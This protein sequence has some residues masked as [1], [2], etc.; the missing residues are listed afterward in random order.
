MEKSV[1]TIRSYFIYLLIFILVLGVSAPESYAATTKDSTDPS[2]EIKSKLEPP[3]D[4]DLLH[5]LPVPDFQL[6]QLHKQKSLSTQRSGSSVQAENF[7]E[8]SESSEPITVIVELATDPL[9]VFEANSPFS[10]KSKSSVN[11][12]TNTLRQ[13]H[14]AFKSAAIL[15]AGATFNREYSNIFNGYSITL[16]ADEVDQLLLIAGVKAVYPNI[17]YKALELDQSSEGYT[18]YMDVSAP[19]IGA[20]TLWASGYTGA[21]IKVGVID[22][23]VDY[24]HP[25]LKDAYKGGYDFVDNDDDPME[26]LPDPTKPIKNG[27]PY[28]TLHGTHVSG[29]IVGQGDPEHPYAGKGWVRGVAPAADLYVYRVLGPY[30]SGTSENVIAA[31]ERA[32]IDDLDVVNLSLGSDLNNEY[33][34]DSIAADNATLAGVTVVLANG[35][36]GPNDQT[37]GSPAASELSISVGASVPPVSTPIFISSAIGNIYAQISTFS[38]DLGEPNQELDLVY[39]NYGQESDYSNLDV[40]GKTVIVS[41]GALSFGEKSMNATAAGA[42]ALIIHNNTPGEFGATLGEPG[43]Y[44]PTYT[45]SQE[46]GLA[47]KDQI[48]QGQPTITFSKI[49]EQDLLA[50]FSSRGPALPNYSIKPDFSA[51]GVGIRSSIPAF[52]GDYSN[53][54]EDLNGTSMAAP[55][56]AGAVAL[57]LEQTAQANLDL[58]PYQIKSILSNNA[59]PLSDR[60]GIAY[61][62]NQQGAGRI[63]L[64]KST[65]ADAIVKVKEPL[66]TQL[67]NQNITDYYTSSLSYGQQQANSEVSKQITIDNIRDTNQI[68]HA[69]VDWYSNEGLTI[70]P[71]QDTVYVNQG[72]LETVFSVELTI[73]DGTPDGMYDG[74]IVLTEETTLHE[75]RVPFS[76]FVGQSFDLSPITA[77]DFSSVVFSPNGDGVSDTTDVSFAVNDDLEYF[78]FLI[79]DGLTGDAIGYT[80][81]SIAIQPIHEKNYYKYTWDGT[82]TTE[83]SE[84]TLPE[85]VYA[86]VPVIVDTNE[87]LEGSAEFFFVDLNAPEI[88]LDSDNVILLPDQPG[89]GSISGDILD[90]LQ[91]NYLYDGTNLDELVGISAL[92]QSDQGL[93]QIDGTIDATG[94]FNLNLPIVKGENTYSIFAYDSVGNGTQ[95]PAKVIHYTQVNLFSAKSQVAAGEAF[96]VVANY[97]VTEDVYSASFSLTYDSKLQLNSIQ[98]SVLDAVYTHLDQV[99]IDLGNGLKQVNYTGTLPEGQGTFAAFNFTATQAGS[100]PF[101]ISNVELLNEEGKDIPVFGLSPVTVKV[102]APVPGTGPDPDPVVTNPNSGSSSSGSYSGNTTSTPQDNSKKFKAGSL[103]EFTINDI[104][105]ATLTV[106][107]SLLTKQIAS[108]TLKAITLDLS[109]IPVDTYDPF[110]ISISS[111][112]VEQLQQSKKDLILVGSNFEIRIPSQSIS[113]FVSK[114]GFRISMTLSKK[115]VGTIQA[116]DGATGKF[117]AP[118]LMIHGQLKE[119]SAPIQVQL[120]LAASSFTDIQKVGIY[121]L[122]GASQ[123]SYFGIPR[124]NSQKNTIQFSISAPGSFTAIETLKSFVD[125][126]KHWAKHEIEVLAAHFLVKGKPSST[127]YKPQDHVNQAEFNTLLDRLLSRNV[128]WDQRIAELGA[129]DQLTREQVA[130][131]LHEA[132]GNTLSDV[133][134]Q[135]DFKDQTTISPDARAAVAFVVSKGYLQGNPNHSFNPQGTL[136]RAEAAV[137]LYRIGLEAN[138]Y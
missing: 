16:P 27:E 57:I 86:M 137:I 28:N 82:V 23:G 3:S 47:L 1:R 2:L 138:T 97:S 9:K 111:A 80:Y 13:E 15:Q 69:S 10:M 81:D 96:D 103:N 100:Y 134:Q 94:H 54:Y 65:E 114:D 77:V 48:D 75:L 92:V 52:N 95:T 135:L 116:P 29:T 118:T 128:T 98:P 41:R 127:T 60:H 53:A 109:D 36:T 6:P 67:N 79:F 126:S 26:T 11:S 7:V 39:A 90:D 46:D 30:G 63:D 14:S 66:P 43:M 113:N 62:V 32:V 72:A 19:F 83:D 104:L 78:F 131:L 64:V 119:F 117:A 99:S 18:P 130:I 124:H 123:W 31:I 88:S 22:T 56:V 51:P 50:D 122:S 84:I 44:V 112:L 121:S 71:T 106:T 35:N 74:Q 102:A 61:S 24:N 93:Q 21:G 20:D 133:S 89:V 68:Y 12:H 70:Q 45:I 38:P 129:R 73:P 34:P 87:L 37:V 105:G 132:L 5:Q 115:S 55:H 108:S 85:G 33:S 49:E 8:P 58:D 17:E 76:V 4:S 107:P 25:S 125:T 101:T 40:S 91:L 110:H 136:T 120:H 42:K 59:V